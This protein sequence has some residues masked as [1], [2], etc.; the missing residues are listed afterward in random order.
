MGASKTMETKLAWNDSRKY[1]IVFTQRSGSTFLAHCLDSHVNIGCDRG[2]PVN[3]LHPLSRLFPYATPTEKVMAILNRQGYQVNIARVN[4]RHIKNVEP[5]YIRS[6]D[7]VIHLTRENVLRNIVSAYISTMGRKV[8]H[9]YHEQPAQKFNFQAETVKIECER[10]VDNVAKMIEYLVA[11]NSNILHLTYEQIT[12]NKETVLLESEA[13][14]KIVKFLGVMRM[15][16]CTDL[17][18]TNPQP[19]KEIIRNYGEICQILKDTP[20]EKYLEE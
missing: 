8:N 9:A 1:L 4:Y 3:P 7:G 2:E 18:R 11:L 16:L 17:M 20:F 12:G 13:T 15:A 14:D 5:S 6:L 10:Y 19:L